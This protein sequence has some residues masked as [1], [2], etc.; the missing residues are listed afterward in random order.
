MNLNKTL[1]NIENKLGHSSDIV[2]RIIK[3]DNE[4]I[5]YIYLESV[6]SGDKISEFLLKDINW[7]IK[8]KKINLFENLFKMLKNSILNSHI[9]TIEK[10]E[11]IYYYLACG[12][13]LIC[14]SDSK[15]MIVIENKNKLDRGVSESNN[16]SVLK[17]PKDSFTENNSTNLGLIRKRIKDPNLRFDEIIVG[18]RTKT[19]VTVCYIEDITNLET[20]EE[21]KKKISDIDV[22]GI[23][24][25][26]YIREFIT[27]DQISTFPKYKSTE[28]PDLVCASLLE[29]KFA[30]I[31][32]SSPT[33]IIA[34]TLFIDF[35]HNVEDYYQK[36]KNVKITRA[37]RIIS[38]L[39]TLLTPGFYIALTT[40]NQE[41]IPNELLISLSIQREG[42]PFST[43]FVII[44]MIIAFEIL[45][46]CDLR[47][48]SYMG[49]AISI[50][51]ALILGDAAVN[52]GIVSSIVIIIVAL[53]SIS[54][55][56]FTDIDFINGIRKWRF[57]FI[58]FSSIFGL[59]GFT[60]ALLIIIVRLCEL[61]SAGIPYLAP[62]TPF[63]F[64]EQ[65]DVLLRS[66]RNKLKYRPRY[67]NIQDNVRMRDK[68]EKN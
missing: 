50:V 12:Y 13:S 46:E 62:I 5:L 42:V 1:K 18:R 14:T 40:F 64:E 19:K 32:E 56:L 68:N 47:S 43:S 10:E 9:K 15:K 28:K 11:D 8:N 36:S 66:P 31:V 52:A 49:T 6:S 20:I 53:T 45:R 63:G 58:I 44:L 48:S 4:K 29:G 22:D 39:I 3:I 67:L 30:I 54:S 17:G 27:T 57:L 51:G 65:K 26:E 2:S 34:P 55:L 25:S 38:F 59:V 60:L 16:E 23:L 24:D 7:Y 37:L 33:A 35:M 21:V 61:K 41:I